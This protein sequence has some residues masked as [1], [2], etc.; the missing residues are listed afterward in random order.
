M[1]VLSTFPNPNSNSFNGMAFNGTGD[2]IV[3]WST[4]GGETFLQ[5]HDPQTGAVLAGP[6]KVSSTPS[7]GGI[8]VDLASCYFPPSLELRKD[9]VSRAAAT[10]QFALSITGGNLTQGNTA[11]TSGTEPGVQAETAGPVLARAGT[12]YAFTEAGAGTTDLSSYE[13]TWQCVDSGAGGAVVASGTGQTFTLAPTP[14][15]AIVCTF[16]NTG[17]PPPS[18]FDVYVE[19]LRPHQDG[20]DPTPIGGAEFQ[21]LADDNGS[22]GE[23]VDTTVEEVE[24]GRFVIEGLAPGTYWLLETKAPPGYNLLPEAIAFTVDATGSVDLGDDPH[25]LVQL[26]AS[27]A[28]G[29]LDT[30]EV[31]NVPVIGLPFTGSGVAPPLVALGATALFAAA[32]SAAVARRRRLQEEGE[33]VAQ[34]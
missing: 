26:S 17:T 28:G 5:K 16:T 22:P 29:A 3:E 11:T 23:P 15:Q 8:G 7:G 1:K 30:L 20:E 19:K 2:V 4:A 33:P 34:T 9:V 13:T 10:D 31:T 18:E 6:S 21:L 24:D 25:P 12:T 14:G 32:V 27:V